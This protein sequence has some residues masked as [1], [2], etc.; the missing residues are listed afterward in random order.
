ME[1]GLRRKCAGK[2]EAKKRLIFIPSL[3]HIHQNG[4]PVC[5]GRNRRLQFKKG[6]ATAC[7]NGDFVHMECNSCNAVHTPIFKRGKKKRKTR[8][9]MKTIVPVLDR[10]H[11]NWQNINALG[12][13]TSVFDR[14]QQ[15]GRQNCGNATRNPLRS[16]VMDSNSREDKHDYCSDFLIGNLGCRNDCCCLCLGAAST[17]RNRSS[18]LMPLQHLLA[19]SSTDKDDWQRVQTTRS[20]KYPN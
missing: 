16:A 2:S 18:T 10:L 12:S 15:N 1:R 8:A 11:E 17:G 4:K 14:H 19:L 7:C 9:G 13:S 20:P 3:C 5:A 6:G